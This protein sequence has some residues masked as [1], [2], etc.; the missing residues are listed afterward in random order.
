MRFNLSWIWDR[1]DLCGQQSFSEL[2]LENIIICVH[3]A[4]VLEPERIINYPV[5][6]YEFIPSELKFALCQAECVGILIAGLLKQ[7][8]KYPEIIIPG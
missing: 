2:L 3:P 8:I 1:P 4:S 5:H 7:L 6:S